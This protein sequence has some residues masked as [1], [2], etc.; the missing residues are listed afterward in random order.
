MHQVAALV[1]WSGEEPMDV[2]ELRAWG[3]ERMPHYQVPS[4]IV[5]A[6]GDLPRNNMGKVNKK[7]VVREFFSDVNKRP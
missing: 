4:V 7:Q 2:L 3:Q 6:N 1:V 5:S